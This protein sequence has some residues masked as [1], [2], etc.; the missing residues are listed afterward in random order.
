MCVCARACVHMSSRPGG[1]RITS[2]EKGGVRKSHHWWKLPRGKK[3]LRSRTL[4]PGE[5]LQTF[6][7]EKNVLKT[8]FSTVQL[9]WGRSRVLAFPLGS[10]LFNEHRLPTTSGPGMVPAVEEHGLCC[11]AA[12]LLSRGIGRK[13]RQR[14]KGKEKLSDNDGHH[15]GDEKGE[16]R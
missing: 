10:L 1:G 3:T 16:L 7:V 14:N 9:A 6:K 11:Q 4:E 15:A 5:L 12:R 8:L 2:K 13:T